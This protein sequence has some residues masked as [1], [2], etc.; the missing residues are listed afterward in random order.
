MSA[1]PEAPTKK[2]AE[3]APKRTSESAT[4]KEK[5]AERMKYRIVKK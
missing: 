5:L 3:E 1:K 2:P 4:L